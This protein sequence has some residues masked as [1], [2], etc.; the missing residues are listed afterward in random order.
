ME[1]NSIILVFIALLL[2]GSF[3]GLISGF[4][5]VGG[6]VIVVPV[7]LYYFSDKVDPSSL[8]FVATAT[9]L[10]V[11]IF[12]AGFSTKRHIKN[13]NLFKQAVLPLALGAFIGTFPGNYLV[14]KIPGEQ[15]Y[16]AFSILLLL[17]SIKMFFEKKIIVDEDNT[18]LNFTK[19]LVTGMGV[20]IFS[21]LTGLG[22]GVILVPIL[23]LLFKFPLKKAVGTTAFV[24]LFNTIPGVLGRI[25]SG[26]GLTFENFNFNLGYLIPEL[27]IPLII[28][29]SIFAP[30][31]AQLNYKLDNKI[32]KKIAGVLFFIISIRM[33]LRFIL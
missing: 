27:S 9:S 15:L 32:F 22:G 10:S 6:G 29:V 20:G 18:N 25:Y 13:N 2:V 30:I 7:M 1:N 21:V 28:G 17:I 31:G 33:I 3:T 5:G 8:F 19:L 11:A 4:L 16:F 24:M 26:Y 14:T 23:S 12:S